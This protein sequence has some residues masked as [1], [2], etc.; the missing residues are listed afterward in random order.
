MAEAAPFEAWTFAWRLAV[1]LLFVLANGFFVAAEFA[2]VKVR[3]TR[4]K[5]LADEG[6]GGA[7][8][9]RHI[10]GHLDHYLSAC[11]LGITISSLILGWLAEPAVAELLLAAGSAAGLGI[12]PADP[13]LHGVALALA[14]AVV[15]VLHMTLGEQAPKLWAIHR[16]EA[17]ALQ[18]AY[19]LRVFAAIFRPLIAM[20]N[21]ISNV[22]LRAAGLS[23]GELEDAHSVDE[24][25]SILTSSAHAGHISGRQLELAGNVLGMMGLEVRHILVPRVDVSYLS[26]ERSTE[27]NLR[28]IRESGHS[29]LPLCRFGLDG[30]I[31]IVHARDVMAALLD[32]GEPD[33]ERLARKPIFAPDTQPLSRL[34]LRMQRTRSHCT[35]VVDEHGTAVGLAFLEDVLEEIVGPIQDEFDGE[36]RGVT[37]SENAI[38]MPGSIPLPEAAELLDSPDLGDESDTI[39]G[40]VVALLGRLP[41][42]G[43]Q[44]QIGVYRVTVTEVGRRRVTRLRFERAPGR[45]KS[46]DVET[47]PVKDAGDAK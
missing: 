24:L 31:G 25:R 27:E 13:V 34:L 7:R 12:D 8:V 14:L 33:F 18:V 30:V 23:P 47:D 20:I 6:S 2:L 45:T 29:R 32:E 39:G 28:T 38:E 44:L 1:T 15:T 5:A 17:T 46:P 26:L 3:A 43:D 19:P 36:A 10:H 35:V 21:A 40:Y 11:Q 37:E 9:A 4:L 41:R 22:M 16:A 42:S